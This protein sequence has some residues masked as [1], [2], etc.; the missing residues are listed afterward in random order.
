M[1]SLAAGNLNLS[2]KHINGD[3]LWKLSDRN[4][5]PFGNDRLLKITIRQS[6]V[7][8]YVRH[9]RDKSYTVDVQLAGFLAKEEVLKALL[10]ARVALTLVKKHH[11]NSSKWMARVFDTPDCYLLLK[12]VSVF[13]RKDRTL[14][15]I[16]DILKE[17]KIRL[18]YQRA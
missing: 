15:E 16:T 7:E 17:M 12:T 10:P 2:K 4:G 18:Q 1:V 6:W 11:N 5:G 13:L 9:S 8:N 14:D 3:T